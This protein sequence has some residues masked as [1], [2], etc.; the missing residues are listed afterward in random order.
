MDASFYIFNASGKSFCLPLITIL[1]ARKILLRKSKDVLLCESKK[2]ENNREGM[3]GN[4]RKKR[5]RFKK[6]IVNVDG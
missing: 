2:E 4:S 3:T 1:K 5:K 6:K